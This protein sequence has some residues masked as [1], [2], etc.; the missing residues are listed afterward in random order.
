LVDLLRVQIAVF[1]FG[2][3]AAWELQDFV[4]IVEDFFGLLEILVVD[5]CFVEL[6]LLEEWLT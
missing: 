6:R 2:S 1:S 4:E 5:S 3:E